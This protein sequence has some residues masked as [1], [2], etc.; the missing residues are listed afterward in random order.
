MHRLSRYVDAFAGLRLLRNPGAAVRHVVGLT[1]D[2]EVRYEL[3]NGLSL[4]LDASPAGRRALLSI[5]EIF[6]REV[7]RID[8]PGLGVILDVGANIGLFAAFAAARCPGARVHAFEPEPSNLAQLR[9]TLAANGLEQRVQVYACAVAESASGSVDLFLN[10]LNGRAHSIVAE[11]LEAC[12]ESK[13]LA[14]DGVA[15]VSVPARSLAQVFV[16]CGIE[17]CDLMKMDIEGAEYG[18]LYSAPQSLL[19]RIDRIF[20]ECH[21]L[22]RVDAR[23]EVGAMA[24]FLRASGFA[25]VEC[26]GP[27]L[28]AA[29]IGRP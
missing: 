13:R 27:Y 28:R 24:E 22:R 3:R 14:R 12:H 5:Q 29:R 23:F 17:H 7:Y 10:A 11:K 26:D 4:S 25:S 9:R 8:D 6:G 16:D 15:K 21:D 1:R 20:L 2:G 18:V 19:A